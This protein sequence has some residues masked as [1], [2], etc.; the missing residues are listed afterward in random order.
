[1][2][3][4]FVLIS[5]SL[6]FFVFKLFLPS[7]S[8][9]KINTSEIMFPI[10]T[11][12]DILGSEYFY[13]VGTDKKAVVLCSPNRKLDDKKLTYKGQSDC[14]LFLS[15]YDSEYDCTWGCVGLGSCRAI[16]PHNAI[17]IVNHT[18]VV[19]GSC[20]GCG[21]CVDVCPMHLIHLI[22][23]TENKCVLCQ[24]PESHAVSCSEYLKMSEVTA[25]KDFLYNFYYKCVNILRKA[26][27]N[28]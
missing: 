1:M 6:L 27:N 28:R 9:Q 11:E 16:C 21:I 10:E 14:S 18:A 19:N 3:I 2:I 8:A 20:N 26:E 4:T 15:A 7:L 17:N 13:N 22:P 23:S 12:A 24:A 5:A 25:K